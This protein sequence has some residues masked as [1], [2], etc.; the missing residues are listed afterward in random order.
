MQQ[1]MPTASAWDAPM[2]GRGRPRWRPIVSAG[3]LIGALDLAFAWAFWAPRGVTLQR[4]TQSIGAG[5]FGDR[6][7]SMGAA[8]AVVGTVSHFAIAIAFVVIYALAARRAAVLVRRP[9]LPGLVY[10]VGLYLA[11]N[12]VVLPLSAAGSP[13]FE[14]LPWVASSV[15]VH[16]LIGVICAF[17]ARRALRG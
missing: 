10:G 7:F 12:L 3:L 9:V 15:V 5:W 4:I 6:S 13:G 11:M 2:I 17:A 14:N 8:S 1:G 16:A